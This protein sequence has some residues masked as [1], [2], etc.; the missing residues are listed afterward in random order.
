ML[1]ALMRFAKIDK[2]DFFTQLITVGRDMVGAVTVEEM[3]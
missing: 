3:P 2:D 1:E